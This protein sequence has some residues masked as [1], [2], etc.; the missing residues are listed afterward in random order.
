MVVGMGDGGDH[1]ARIGKCR[2]R[3]VMAAEPAEGAMGN[4]DEREPFTLDRAVAD[5][6]HFNAAQLH[7]LW[8]FTAGRPNGPFEHRHVPVRR[9]FEN[10]QARGLSV[11]RE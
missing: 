3:V 1:I 10:A 9:D 2:R 5:A 6:G 11:R 8:G 7:G 4:D